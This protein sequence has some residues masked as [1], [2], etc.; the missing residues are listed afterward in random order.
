MITKR[1]EDLKAFFVGEKKQRDYRQAA[2]DPYNLAENFAREGLCDLDRATERL[3]YVLQ[4]EK[5][6]IFPFEKIAFLRTVPTIP[7][8]FTKEEMQE[9]PK[10]HRIHEKGD[11]CNINVDYHKLL[12]VGF[13]KMKKELLQRIEKFDLHKEH[14]KSYY[15][16]QQIR[17]L[18]A[19]QK[20]ADKYRQLAED[21][22]NTLV[23]QSLATVPA[24]APQNWLEALQF[25]RIIHFVMWCGRNYH[26]T[27]GRFDQYM[28]SFFQKDLQAG[29]Y[30]RESALELLEEFFISFNRDSD[31]YPGMQQ[32]DNGQS[33]V[34]GG[35]NPDGTDS[36]NLLSELCMEASYDLK[37]IDPKINLRVNDKTPDSTYFLGTRLT[38]QGL[39][40]PQY[41]ND[42]VVIPGLI[43]LGY[44][45][46]DAYNYVV[47]ACWEFIIPGKAM[48]IPNI[49]AFSFAGAMEKA[50]LEH[51][52]DC[53][54]YQEY[55]G[56]VEENIYSQVKE[57]C[58]NTKGLY[59]FPAPFL[60]LMM[61]GCEEAG[62]DVSFSCIYNN[63]GI[64]GT[65]I[66]T[67]ADSMACIKKYIYEQN[68]I[69]KEKLLSAIESDYKNDQLLCNKLR[70]D[71]PKMG[72]DDDF[73][74]MIACRLLDVFSDSVKGLKNDRGGIFRVG[75][76]SAMYYI[77]HSKDLSATP[78]G[79]HKGEGIPANFSP[80]LF[81]HVRG[82]VSIIKSF[83]KENLQNVINGG[84]LTLELHDTV[85]KTPESIQKV[86]VLVKSYM[87]MGGHQLQINSVNKEELLEAQKHPE[88]YRNLIV[89]VWG[90]SGYFVELDT[91]YQ[92]HIIHRMEL[93]L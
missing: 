65:G 86:A 77:W 70:Y 89:R 28:F 78:D 20:L 22:G 12:Y 56:Y 57:I 68:S 83:S 52:A 87:D 29:I 59:F 17:I 4:E 24:K 62:R 25:F 36:Y 8:L 5:P 58:E 81:C 73:V 74:D 91:C 55:A 35:L 69:S 61:E 50:T 11:V 26:N 21:E 66:A 76:G 41:S 37:I 40:F 79:R 7:E 46:S 6:V 90:W 93:S 30:T 39:G 13:D 34:L 47:A 33:L 9:F 2:K 82:P 64:H 19:I 43:K 18:E 80:S 60:S 53:A 85:F 1:I 54:D 49:D 38:K 48:D 42:E 44:A 3:L 72:N 71:S 92:D 45:P 14:E 63:Y 51:L 88:K 10:K 67:A 23:A 16:T 27:L 32:G 84:P 15:L 75:T 31:L